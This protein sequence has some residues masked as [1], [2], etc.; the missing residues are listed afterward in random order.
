MASLAADAI[1]GW[2]GTR[3]LIALRWRMVRNDSGRNMVKTG[4]VTIV[5]AVLAVMN[6]GLVA[7]NAALSDLGYQT[8]LARTWAMMLSYGY[9][10]SVGAFTLGGVLAVAVFAPLTGTSTQA[11]AAAEDLSGVRVPRLHRY[12]DSLVLNAISGLGVL[13]LLVLTGVAAL[14]T[15]DG[16]KLPA[17]VWAWTLW[18]LAITAMTSFG[19]VLEWAVR[20]FGV[21]TR[22]LAAGL[23]FAV[24]G[25]AVAIDPFNGRQL[26]GLATVF[27]DAMRA[28]AE[29]WS[30]AAVVLPVATL[31]AAFAAAVGGLFATRSALL[32]APPVVRAGRFRRARNLL[33]SPLGASWS[34]LLRTLWRTPEVRRSI[35]GLVAVGVVV[36]ALIEL[37]QATEFSLIAAAPL[38]VALS[39][40]SNAFGLLGTGMV[41]LG[42]QPNG[43]RDLPRLVFACHSAMSAAMIAALWCASFLA[44]NA[45]PAHLPRI[46]GSAALTIV[47]SAALSTYFSVTRPRR[48][49]LTSRGD[50]LLPP[51]AALGYLGALLVTGPL[52]VVLVATTPQPWFQAAVIV[53]MLAFA[54]TLLWRADRRWADREHRAAAISVVSAA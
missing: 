33:S 32:L 8:G 34:L 31:A 54:A 1:A 35:F 12:F 44:G 43:L 49:R 16:V 42:S 20:R 50:A 40:S 9:Y 6:L 17:L 47:V 22:F 38:T 2:Y 15:M 39:W 5:V 13:Q 28:M 29:G 7:Q 24:I 10:G 51:M 14:M 18:A 26:F 41:W 53:A 11:L 37:D 45:D 21:R 48:A 19:W 25:V 52:P 30:L 27:S 36:M 46:V 4:G 3:K 23:A